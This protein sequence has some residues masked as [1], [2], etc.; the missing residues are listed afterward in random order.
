M[1]GRERERKRRGRA[2]HEA[3]K[4]KLKYADMEAIVGSWSEA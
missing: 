1:W 2:D 3:E 4:N